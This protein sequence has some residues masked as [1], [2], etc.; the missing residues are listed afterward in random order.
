MV[1]FRRAS[2]QVMDLTIIIHEISL[3]IC[4]AYSLIQRRIKWRDYFFFVLT[5]ARLESHLNTSLLMYWFPSIK[6]LFWTHCGM[7]LLSAL[8]AELT[9]GLMKLNYTEWTNCKLS[10]RYNF[11][12]SRLNITLAL[13]EAQMQI[14]KFLR[15]K[16]AHNFAK[17]MN[18]SMIARWKQVYS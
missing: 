6:V 8:S 15:Q 3:Y 4:T 9:D 16:E 11:H 12:L 1:V 14:L 18:I 7:V 10:D 17:K 5:V 13:H 2:D